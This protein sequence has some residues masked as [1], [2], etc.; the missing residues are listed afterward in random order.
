MTWGKPSPSTVARWA[1]RSRAS[2]SPTSVAV[3]AL[4]R[5]TAW[6]QHAGSPPS[7]ATPA[8]TRPAA[9]CGRRSRWPPA[10][11]GSARGPARRR[12]SCRRRPDGSRSARGRRRGRRAIRRVVDGDDRGDHGIE[13]HDVA[14]RADAEPGPPRRLEVAAGDRRPLQRQD[15]PVAVPRQRQRNEVGDAVGGRSGDPHVGR[16][17]CQQRQGIG[18]ALGRRNA[19]GRPCVGPPA[20]TRRRGRRSPRPPA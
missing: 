9:A 4:G 20:S 1:T 18:L 8:T 2:S 13:Q 3:S 5:V 7:S 15:H 19:A 6:A 17:R 12:R 11:P 14:S 10:M 16:R